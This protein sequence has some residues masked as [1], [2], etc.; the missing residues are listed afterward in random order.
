MAK[1]CCN[2][3][4]SKKTQEKYQGVKKKWGKKK[5]EKL[6]VLKKGLLTSLLR[7]K[8]IARG[9]GVQPGRLWYLL[10]PPI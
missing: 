4:V 8:R 3:N 9:E 1:S 10:R 5:E 2:G 7:Q 6:C